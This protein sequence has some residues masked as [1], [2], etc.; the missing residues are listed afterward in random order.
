MAVYE[1][2]DGRLHSITASTR[3]SK[4]KKMKIKVKTD[5]TPTEGNYVTPAR[6]SGRAGGEQ[7]PARD[8]FCLCSW[9]RGWRGCEGCEQQLQQHGRVADRR[10]GCNA[11]SKSPVWESPG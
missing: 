10:I 5:A 2:T 7:P 3:K 11:P 9:K 6:A 4:W 8:N 1:K